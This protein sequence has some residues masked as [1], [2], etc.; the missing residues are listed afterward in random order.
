MKDRFIPDASRTGRGHGFEKMGI[1]EVVLR[2]LIIAGVA[3]AVLITPGTAAAATPELPNFITVINYVFDGATWSS[4]LVAWENVIFCLII[5]CIL[6]ILCWMATKKQEK[7]PRG[8][9]NLLEWYVETM[10]NFLGG[11]MGAKEGRKYVPFLGTLFIYILSMNYFGLFPL[12]KSPTANLNTTAALAVTVFCYVQY[13]GIRRLGIGGYIHHLAGSPVDVIGWCL[14]PLQLPLHI[15]G[16]FVKPLSL[17]LRLFGNIV[18][19][20][21]LIAVFCMMGA[22]ILA[23]T[24]APVGAPVHF[25]FVFLALLCGLI[26]ALVF[27]LLSSVYFMNM[28][29]HDEH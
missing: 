3:G 24:H 26:Q 16:E 9:Q 4:F 29:P 28:L 12:M 22:G 23:F 1:S 2:C 13:T 25:V 5:A 8:L 21:T 20:D 15:I 6:G 19:E 17:S 7:I 14:V 18:G 27:T 11:I 10:D